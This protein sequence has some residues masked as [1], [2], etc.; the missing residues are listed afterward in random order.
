MKT[1]VATTLV[2]AVPL[3]ALLW[4]SGAV[5]LPLA[6]AGV[7]LIVFFVTFSGCLVLRALRLADLPASAAWVAGVFVSALVVYALVGWFKLLA[8][9]AFALWAAALAACAVVFP[10]RGPR[11]QR[12]DRQEIAGLALCGLVT[13]MWCREIAQ[14]PARLLRDNVLYAWVDYFVHGGIISQFGD[15]LALRGSVF[16][17]DQPPLLYHYAT[18]MLPAALAGLLG[19]AGLPLATSFWLPMGMLTMFAGAYALG[20]G[21]AGPAGAL[22]SVAVLALVPDAASYG[23]R[24]G[25]LSF[26]FHAV[27]TPGA[28]YV[29]GV[30]LASA[31]LLQRWAPGASP[32]P[33]LASAALALGA[34]WFRVHVFAVGFPAW[35]ATA[36]LA[37]RA[38]RARG[39]LFASGGLLAFVLFV[40]AFYAVTDSDLALPIFLDVLHDRQE[41]TAY[42]GI[43]WTL[44][45]ERGDLIAALVGI[46]LVYLAC[47]GA[48]VALY[49]L[50]V[51]LAHRARALQGIDLFPA[52]L[53]AA[54]LAIMLTAP[55]DKHRDSTEFT[56]RPF[57][58]VYAA[59]AVWTV[60]LLCRMFTLRWPQRAPHAWRALLGAS[61]LGVALAWQGAP[62]VGLPKFDWGWQ[63]YP[64]RLDAGLTQAGRFLRE[65]ARAGQVFAVRGLELK[66]APTDPAVQLISLSG[67]PAYLS[68]T[69][70]HTIQGPA[71][72]KLALE[73]YAR[74]AR[75]E[76][77]PSLAAALDEL[78]ELGIAW[79][80]VIGWSGPPWD[81]ARRQTRFFEHNVAIYAVPER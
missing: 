24:N 7:T 9:H 27:V 36:A 42:G 61:L 63:F 81:P 49:P 12:L 30:F 45:T 76:R 46:P 35:L 67:M 66:W 21:L 38:V 41:P 32:R 34:F 54:Y 1:T 39:L 57:V 79:Y 43:Y 50:A 53:L 68:Y 18:Y 78:R 71:Q 65:H 26:H 44:L 13:V 20:A 17:A 37:T 73:R 72:E 75:V 74:L 11:S 28:D 29:I 77:A 6:F 56:V 15:A 51:W 19:E 23:L 4:L 47:L 31:L 3:S 59:V 55:I 10:E 2:L 48:L 33:L 14:A 64:I 80:V 60:C 62:A 52:F 40:L 22:A 70:A 25:F 16:L 69:H 5:P 58:L 8:I